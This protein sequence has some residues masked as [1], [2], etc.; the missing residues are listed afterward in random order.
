MSTTFFKYAERSV[1]SQVNWAE[2]GK[3]MVDMLQEQ[4]RIR[5]EKKAAID[6]ASR[7]YGQE[8][9][10]S[11]QGEFKSANSWILNFSNDAQEARL[12]QDR[13][14]KNGMLSVKD[15]TVMRQNITD[16]TNQ[17]F[18]VFKEYQSKA[19]EIMARTKKGENQDTEAWLMEQLEGLSNFKNTR[20][21]INPTD[22]AISLAP[23]KEDVIDGKKTLVMDNDPNKLLSIN[24][25]KNRLNTRLDIYDYATDASRLVESLG[26]YET[27]RIFKVPGLYKMA[28]IEQIT[29]PTMRTKMSAEDKKTVNLYEEWEKN[30]IGAILANP[31]DHLSL[32][33][34]GIDKVPGTNDDYVPTLDAKLAASSPKYILLKDDGDGVIKPQFTKEQT[35]A[36][37]KFMQTQIRNSI[38]RKVQ[39]SAQAEPQ[40]P[41]P[42]QWMVDRSDKT[43]TAR[44]VVNMIGD[45]YY[46]KATDIN[47]A[48]RYF[49]DS[50]PNAVD[51][52]RTDKGVTV[53]FKDGTSR[54]I[55]FTD[56]SGNE[57]SLEKFIKGAGPLLAEQ[58]DVSRALSR[59][60]Y[61]KGARLSTGLENFNAPVLGGKA[62]EK[63]NPLQIANDHLDISLPISLIGMEEEI[64]VPEIL[65]A[66]TDLG[67][68]A[69]ESGV[70]NNVKITAPNGKS[71]EFGLNESNKTIQ[72]QTMNAIKGFINKNADLDKIG[73]AILS[74]RLKGQ[75]NTSK[76]N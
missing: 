26:D 34:N 29:D 44:D 42:Q 51:V 52:G 24:S 4:N 8:L 57:V 64:A 40:P 70:G 46:G 2:V 71:E 20:A 18:D 48:I 22:Y 25:L 16:G 10:N 50:I 61:K 45:L 31:Y 30:T 59:G 72:A 55:P 53:L 76:Y 37:E 19:S 3:G 75:R 39:L 9:A 47:A 15:Y 69:E 7:L 67:F 28:G 43:K 62:E 1:D 60:G 49:R 11:P 63:R 27:G 23:M 54:D 33:T 32:L 17:L 13:L 74:G 66:V 5:E 56:G 58:M 21:Y 36:A 12:I 6:E 41:Q 38:D 73:M 14:L 35:K 65:A 68:E